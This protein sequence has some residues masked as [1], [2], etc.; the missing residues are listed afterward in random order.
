MIQALAAA[1]GIVSTIAGL[2]DSLHTSD[3]E[4]LAA[5]IEL[6]RIGV[7]A[8]RIEADVLAGVQA[9]NQAEARHR[10]IFVAGW[11]PA[12]GW[13]GAVSLGYQFVLYPLLIWAWAWMQAQGWIPREL[14]PPPV[15]D[16]EALWVI[17]TGMLGLA[18]ARTFEKIKGAAQ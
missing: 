7:E 1:G 6:Q 12:I 11:R 10:S 15:L 8:A 17:I 16:A 2:I 3:A 14:T 4:R 5:Q 18:G 13:I 9:T